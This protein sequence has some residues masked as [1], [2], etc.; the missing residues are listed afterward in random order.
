MFSVPGTYSGGSSASFSWKQTLHE[1]E[2]KAPVP[3]GPPERSVK[4]S[5]T[6]R[7][8]ELTFAAPGTEEVT[9]V[10][11][12]ELTA[13]IVATDSLWSVERDDA[14][15][16]V[17]VVSMRKAKPEVW[18]KLFA[19][20]PE[21]AEAPALLDGEKRAEP[22][23]KAELLKQAK[24]RLKTELDGP[25]RAK[26]YVLE[27]LAGE[28][29][30]VEASELPELPV[31]IVRDCSGCTLT[32]PASLTL[33]K[34]QIERCTNCT[35][36]V[37]AR[38]LTETT[39]VWECTDCTVRLASKASTV[40]VDKCAQLALTYG[41]VEYFDRIMHT[42]PRGLRIAFE[43]APQLG[44]TL[45]LDALRA[46]H[47]DQTIDELTDQ[48][49][50]RRLSS[51]AESLSTEL[52]IRLCNEFPTTEREVKEFEERTRMH[53]AK[54]DEVVDGMLGSSLGKNLTAAER[55]QMKT[56]M[57]E[58]SAA[59][60]AAQQQAEQTAEGRKEARVAFKKGEGNKAFKAAEFQ[61]AAVF[62]TE[63]LSLDAT[64]HAL[65]SNR[66]ACFLK[67]GRYAQAR[68]D[69]LECTRLAPDFAKGHFRLALALQAENKPG[70]ACA[71]FNKCLAIEP[72]N[73]D[74]TAGLNVARMQA[75]RQR[76]QQAGQVDI[77]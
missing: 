67:L 36:D 22:Q 8:L 26:P 42:G 5:F 58:Q 10:A 72:S 68:E 28:T 29:R 16:A 33:I 25:S 61:Q 23:S 48:F 11:V 70:E 20:D 14:G 49:I 18:S 38:V 54:L 76:R 75:E 1:I 63:A 4:C 30:E 34:L 64:Q 53:E 52:I 50:T 66:A 7:R 55:E 57:R 12:G 43:D 24:E 39:E 44:T 60:T 40:Q 31:M 47:N 19:A 69:A 45:E 27:K 65:Y 51:T 13:V 32:L 9:Q 73:K 21:P 37:T 6:A 41:S 3:A 62:Y 71:A 74:A 35:I 56:M 77:N 15:R 17:A 59:A 2:L 46:A